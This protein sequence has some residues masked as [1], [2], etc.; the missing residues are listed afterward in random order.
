MGGIAK[1]RVVY[2]CGSTTYKTSGCVSDNNFK[3]TSDGG[4]TFTNFVK[5]DSNF[6]K[7]GDSGGIV[8]T[9]ADNEYVPCGII[10]GKSKDE[11]PNVF[12]YFVKASEIVYF[13]NVTPF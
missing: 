8:Y 3:V 4:V 13:L 7:R 12:G 9:Y 10:S 6:C 2:K 11:N 1:G 5:V